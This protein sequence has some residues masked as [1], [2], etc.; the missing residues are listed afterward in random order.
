MVAILQSE[1]R[2]TQKDISITEI[3]QVESWDFLN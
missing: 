2:V 3:S 1:G